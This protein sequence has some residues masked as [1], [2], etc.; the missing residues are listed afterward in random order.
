MAVAVK[1]ANKLPEPTKCTPAARPAD[2][3]QGELRERD[4]AGTTAL[5]Q[6]QDSRS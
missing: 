5:D 3:S 1:L 4:A 6:A 2:V